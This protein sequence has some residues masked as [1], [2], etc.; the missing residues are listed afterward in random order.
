[1]NSIGLYMKGIGL[2]IGNVGL[3][4]KKMRKRTSLADSKY[5]VMLVM[6][7]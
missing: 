4:I 1:M 3:S 6:S 2:I 5:W 7:S